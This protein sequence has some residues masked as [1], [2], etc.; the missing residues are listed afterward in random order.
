M[1]LND[2]GGNQNNND[3]FDKQEQLNRIA[4]KVQEMRNLRNNLFNVL[5]LDLKRCDPNQKIDDAL[6]MAT[7]SMISMI[8][9]QLHEMEAGMQRVQAMINNNA[10]L[11]IAQ[12]M[13]DGASQVLSQANRSINGSG[14]LVNTNYVQPE[15]KF[16]N[17]SDQF[18]QKSENISEIGG[19]IDLYQINNNEN[20]GN[21]QINLQ[22]FEQF[23]VSEGAQLNNEIDRGTQKMTKVEEEIFQGDLKSMYD[24]DAQEPQSRSRR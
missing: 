23:A 13:H 22:G 12:Q 1:Q 10:I 15:R 7:I 11:D 19:Q 16:S 14:F 18:F 21:F 24:Q 5:Q 4:F 3:L 9:N 17:F 6:G 2:L 20:Y 8:D